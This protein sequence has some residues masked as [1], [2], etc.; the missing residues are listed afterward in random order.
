MANRRILTSAQNVPLVRF[1]R[2]P[3]QAIAFLR[4][5]SEGDVGLADVVGR[6]GRVFCSVK[7]KDGAH[8]GLGRDQVGVLGH[9]AGSVDF[10]FVVDGLDDFDSWCDVCMG[11]DFCWQRYISRSF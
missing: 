4:V 2:V 11:A 10:A 5:P 9:V 6:V 3:R 7:D 1:S 8:D